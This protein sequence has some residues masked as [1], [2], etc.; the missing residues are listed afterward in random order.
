MPERKDNGGWKT[1][2][3]APEKTGGVILADSTAFLKSDGIYIVVV[4]GKNV[5]IGISE[6]K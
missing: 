1:S 6:Q 3:G 4:A 2:F 5:A